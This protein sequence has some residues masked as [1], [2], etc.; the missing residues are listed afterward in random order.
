MTQEE[1]EQ[2]LRE[3]RE[4]YK[5][6]FKSSNKR[7][8]LNAQQQQDGSLV[9][10][11][12]KRNVFRVLASQVIGASRDDIITSDGTA[13]NCGEMSRTAAGKVRDLGSQAL[14]GSVR[15]PGDHAFC[16][17]D[18]TP[19]GGSPTHVQDMYKDQ[20]A[21]NS[22]VIDP[23]M[24]IAC[25]FKDY[26]AFAAMKLTTWSSKGKHILYHRGSSDPLANEYID[27]FFKSGPLS[28]N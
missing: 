4:Y 24:N 25:P 21:N 16:A 13:G 15:Y 18:Y 9:A 27:G 17:V 26:P 28:F 2:I 14:I 7:Y 19:H 1:A 6:G 11:A 5:Q 10:K 20:R 23:W 22:W 8:V 3:T 12:T